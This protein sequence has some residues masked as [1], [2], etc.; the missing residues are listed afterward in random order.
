[1]G[2]EL[3][4]HRRIEVNAYV[5]YTGSEVLLYHKIENLSLGGMC[6]QAASPETPGTEVEL[7]I[8]FPDLATTLELRGHVVWVSPQ[9]PHNMGIRFA[10]LDNRQSAVLESYLSRVTKLA[11]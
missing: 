11:G 6:I 5:D 7:V 4:A 9:P 2:E 3:R 10:L 1:M 8:N